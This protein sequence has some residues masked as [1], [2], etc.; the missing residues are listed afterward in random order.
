MLAPADGEVVFAG[1][2]GGYGKLIKIKHK[3]GIVTA[4]GHLQRIFVKKGQIIKIGQK[5]GKMGSTGRST[6]QHLHYEIILNGKHV[7]PINF[8]RQGRR[9]LTRNIIQTSIS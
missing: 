1:N 2:N 7:N 9:L 8:M 6:G 3:Y 4:Y 5:I